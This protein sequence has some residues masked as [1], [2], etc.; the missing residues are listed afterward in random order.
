MISVPFDSI[1]DKNP[2]L[3][4]LGNKKI[5]GTEQI[6][7]S[8]QQTITQA[9]LTAEKF[10]E[11]YMSLDISISFKFGE[12]SILT[13]F[14]DGDI[15]F[16]DEDMK[17]EGAF[18]ATYLREN[19]R[20]DSSGL[21]YHLYCEMQTFKRIMSRGRNVKEGMREMPEPIPQY[22]MQMKDG[23]PALFRSFVK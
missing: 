23:A 18:I 21:Q 15:Y 16:R 3:I 7:Q 9:I 8:S 10:L 6:S 19:M 5:P 12:V 13:V 14:C 17:N 4:R 2:Y 11:E 22:T 1:L 20:A